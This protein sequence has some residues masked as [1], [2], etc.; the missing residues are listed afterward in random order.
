VFSVF[1]THLSESFSYYYC[2][3][4]ILEEPVTH[5]FLSALFQVVALINHNIVDGSVFFRRC[6]LPAL[7]ESLSMRSWSLLLVWLE[8]LHVSECTVCLFIR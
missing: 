3:L 6:L 7:R 5:C 2:C 4:Y 1:Y 8:A